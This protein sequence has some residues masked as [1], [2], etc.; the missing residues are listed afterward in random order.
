[1]SFNIFVLSC[2]VLSCMILQIKQVIAL[3]KIADQLEILNNK[4][5][6]G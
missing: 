1:M 2:I 4:R 3:S 5:F 6:K